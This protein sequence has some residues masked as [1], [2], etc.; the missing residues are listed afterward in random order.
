MTPE[1]EH[2]LLIRLDERTETIAKRLDAL[3]CAQCTTFRMFLQA[4]G[5]NL[6]PLAIVFTFCLGAVVEFFRKKG[7]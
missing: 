1:E 4:M 5:K 7:P 6:W 3:P 2:E